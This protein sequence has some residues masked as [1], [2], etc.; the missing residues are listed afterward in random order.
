MEAAL[1]TC[2]IVSLIF[3]YPSSA[4]ADISGRLACG[5]S[6]MFTKHFDRQIHE[7][8]IRLFQYDSGNP[9][10]LNLKDQSEQTK[11]GSDIQPSKIIMWRGRTAAFDC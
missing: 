5:D 10:Y 9:N 3:F 7:L 6:F 2:E 1:F 4:L 8:E 11:N